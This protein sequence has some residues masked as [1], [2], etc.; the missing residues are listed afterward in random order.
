MAAFG[1]D[2]PIDTGVIGTDAIKVGLIYKPA[3]VTAVGA[4]QT[5]TSADDPRF[6]DTR[7]RPTLAQTFAQNSTGE[8]ITVST[9]LDAQWKKAFALFDWDENLS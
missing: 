9:P 7:S 3:A 2:A 8:R 4:F 1:R 6:I 5:L